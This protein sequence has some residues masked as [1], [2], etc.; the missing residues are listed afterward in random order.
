MGTN[1]TVVLGKPSRLRPLDKGV[2]NMLVAGL[3]EIDCE[4]VVL[5][6][7]HRPVAEFLVEH[8]VADR[9][10]ADP[11]DLPAAPR[12]RGALDQKRPARRLCLVPIGTPAWRDARR[13]SAGPIGCRASPGRI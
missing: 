8:A 6:G 5:D 9:E 13:P 7:P 3:L 4:L 2:H 11:L 1:S 10:A 12:R